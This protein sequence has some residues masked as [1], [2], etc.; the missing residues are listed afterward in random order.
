[1][2]RCF[3]VRRPQWPN[4]VHTILST[5]LFLFPMRDANGARRLRPLGWLNKMAQS[6]QEKSQSK[7]NRDSNYFVCHDLASFFLG[8]YEYRSGSG[9]T[10]GST[11][12]I[13]T[14]S[15]LHKMFVRAFQAK[16]DK[17]TQLAKGPV[18]RSCVIRGYSKR[19]TSFL[20]EKC[21]TDW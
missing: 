18:N 19:V 8:M 17:R 14:V 1:M 6:K 10:Q 11:G 16:C 9:Q 13:R 3:K 7:H 5:Q 4:S 12:R 2:L 20:Y 21:W 15:R